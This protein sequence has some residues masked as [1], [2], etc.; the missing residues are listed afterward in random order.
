[1]SG[2]NCNQSADS[3]S[4]GA[5]VGIRECSGGRGKE[6]ETSLIICSL[7]FGWLLQASFGVPAAKVSNKTVLRDRSYPIYNKDPG[8]EREREKYATSSQSHNPLRAVLSIGQ[9]KL[10]RVSNLWIRSVYEGIHEHSGSAG[11]ED[12]TQRTG[13]RFGMRRN[14]ANGW[15]RWLI[16]WCCLGS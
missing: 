2:K 14:G 8:E 7:P 15:S 6:E 16:R 9:R 12:G 5:V 4:L 10:A 11:D 13:G 3:R 1:M